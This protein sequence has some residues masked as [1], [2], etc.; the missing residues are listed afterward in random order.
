MAAGAP[1]VNAG[2]GEGGRENGESEVAQV[3]N[4]TQACFTAQ[5]FTACGFEHFAAAVAPPHVVTA[6]SVV[7]VVSVV[8]ADGDGGVAGGVDRIRWRRNQVNARQPAPTSTAVPARANATDDAR[9]STIERDGAEGAHRT[10]TTWGG[11]G[12]GGRAAA[13]RAI[14]DGDDRDSKFD[15]TDAMVHWRIV[16]TVA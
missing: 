14:G 13:S 6:M 3:R 15:H 16:V 11:V 9:R 10:G 7:S 5:A 2:D 8:S 4:S 12:G 1:T